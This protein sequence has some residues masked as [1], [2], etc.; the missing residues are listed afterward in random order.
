M[1]NGEQERSAPSPKLT[2]PLS[3]RWLAGGTSLL[4]SNSLWW[5]SAYHIQA[6]L[7]A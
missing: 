5:E 4:R 2:P 3:V 1:L 7:S 6:V